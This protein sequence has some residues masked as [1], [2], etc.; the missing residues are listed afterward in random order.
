MTQGIAELTLI[1]ALPLGI[2]FVTLFTMAASSERNTKIAGVIISTL[3]IVVDCLFFFVQNTVITLDVGGGI[4]LSFLLLFLFGLLCLVQSEEWTTRVSFLLFA[5]CML[6]GLI[7]TACYER[8]SLVFTSSYS[9]SEKISPSNK[10]ENIPSFDKAD[11]ENNDQGSAKVQAKSNRDESSDDDEEVELAPEVMNRLETY[12]D[13]ADAVIDKMYNIIRTIEAFEPMEQN[14]SEMTRESRSQQ[15]L[16]INS[17]ASTLNRRAIGLFHPLQ[18]REAHT[19]L[20]QASETIRSASHELYAYCLLEDPAEQAKKF[21][22][23]HEM[24]AI[25]KKHI[26]QFNKIIEN[27]TNNQPQQ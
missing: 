10:Y 6:I 17:K 26:E 23:A 18:A 1:Y 13:K 20:V 4:L 24:L 11:I 12:A 5:M 21:T 2:S 22:Q 25:A 7:G 19:E 27:L 14:V 9:V 16:A 15:A 8:P 3:T